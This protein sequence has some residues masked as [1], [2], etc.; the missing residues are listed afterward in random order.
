MSACLTMTDLQL[1]CSCFHA[2][3]LPSL[4]DQVL[5]QR[6]PRRIPTTI[7]PGV[8]PDGQNMPQ[9]N[10]YDLY[11]EITGS[12]FVAPRKDNLSALLYRIRPAVAHQGFA[13]LPDNP[14]PNATGLFIAWRPFSLPSSGSKVD[15]LNGLKTLA[16]SGEPTLNEGLAIHIYTANSSME[17]RAVVN[18]DGDMLIVPQLGRLDIQTEFG[19]MMVRPGEICVIQ[20]GIRFKVGL[21]DGD[22]RGCEWF[23][24]FDFSSRA[25]VLSARGPLKYEGLSSQQ[26]ESSR[27]F[28][29]S[30]FSRQTFKKFSAHASSCQNSALSEGMVSLM[31]VTSS[32][33]SRASISISLIGKV[34]LACLRKLPRRAF[35]TRCTVVY[36]LGGKSK[37][38]SAP[39]TDF[40]IFSPRWDVASNTYRPPYYHRNASSE[41]MGLIYVQATMGVEATT[42]PL[43]AQVMNVVTSL[44]EV[45]WIFDQYE[46]RQGIDPS[47]DVLFCATVSY[48]VFK[49]ATEADLQPVRIS[50]GT[51]GAFNLEVNTMSKSVGAG[52]YMFL[53]HLNSVDQNLKSHGLPGLKKE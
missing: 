9:K 14:D 46:M 22:S 36:K 38:P 29:T 34:R 39:L 35:L 3:L 45:R 12:S 27:M 49:E 25:E 7:R 42:L 53:K 20:K 52:S 10:K 28:L 1:L 44:M 8:L 4:Q 30:E 51:V 13:P 23:M 19:K 50:E 26:V 41:F 5:L 17:N 11:T 48:E 18:A 6:L 15:F 33:L 31:P 37:N 47:F 40:L 43:E 2:A 24:T 21:P 32:S 16:G